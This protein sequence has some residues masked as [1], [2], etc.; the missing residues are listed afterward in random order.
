MK[1][2]GG[3]ISTL[4]VQYA[5]YASLAAEVFAGEGWK[6]NLAT[7]TKLEGVTALNCTDYVR[8]AVWMTKGTLSFWDRQ[9]AVP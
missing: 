7:E 5:D 1:K 2:E 6:Q 4:A 9:S 8:P 3:E